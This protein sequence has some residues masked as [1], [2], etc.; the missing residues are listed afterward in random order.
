MRLCSGCNPGLL[1]WLPLLQESAGRNTLSLQGLRSEV[2]QALQ[3]L[4]SLAALLGRYA[5]QHAVVAQELQACQMA[6]LV[7]PCDDSLMSWA[8]LD[9][10]PQKPLAGTPLIIMLIHELLVAELAGLLWSACSV[11]HTCRRGI[12]AC[13]QCSRGNWHAE[14]LQLRRTAARLR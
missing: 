7:G 14:R 9:L 10:P 11:N 1:D 2:Q 5:A 13:W 3:E 8:D 6:S 12:R 4:Q